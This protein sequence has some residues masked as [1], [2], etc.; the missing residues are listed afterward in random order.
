MALLA[1]VTSG[2]ACQRSRSTRLTGQDIMAA[3]DAMR[4]SL[5]DSRFLAGRSPDSPPMAIVIN[6]V[7]NLTSDVIPIPEQWMY[8]ARV[9]NALPIQQLAKQRNIRFVI[10][11]ERIEALR[12]AG[13]EVQGPGA[14]EPTHLM[15]ATFLSARRAG[16]QPGAEVTDIRSDYYFMEYA[17]F[18]LADRDIVWTDR[19]E[20]KRQAEGALID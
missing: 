3:T 1:A 14:L 18:D 10:S 8:V 19:F 7:Q 11:P 16:R 9:I 15:S 13:F 5:A 20:F 4:Q 6:R 17:I 12:Q 2:P